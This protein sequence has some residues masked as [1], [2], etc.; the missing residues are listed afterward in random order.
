MSNSSGD[1]E[2][3]FRKV[4]NKD[5]EMEIQKK[6]LAAFS[7]SM[8]KSRLQ[9]ACDKMLVNGKGSKRKAWMMEGKVEQE[10]KVVSVSR[11]TGGKDRHS[12][13]LTAKGLRDRRV[14]LSVPTALQLY[15]LQDRLGYE[16]PSKAV[17]WLIN[18]A[19]SAIDELP[20]LDPE[21]DSAASV[22]NVAHL[23]S[24]NCSN[25]DH[26]VGSPR[27][28]ATA[29][30]ASALTGFKV[31]NDS[32]NARGTN[33]AKAIYGKPLS[34]TT[35]KE[36]DL[37]RTSSS[38]SDGSIKGS[39]EHT[40]NCS[41]SESTSRI[42]SKLK[43]SELATKKSVS[44]GRYRPTIQQMN[45]MQ[46]FLTTGMLN[47]IFPDTFLPAESK[48][49]RDNNPCGVHTQILSKTNNV[50]QVWDY[51]SRLSYTDMLCTQDSHLLQNLSSSSTAPLQKSF[52]RVPSSPGSHIDR[53]S[54]PQSYEMPDSSISSFD[55]KQT[56]PFGVSIEQQCQGQGQDNLCYAN[57][58]NMNM[59][60]VEQVH[61]QQQQEAQMRVKQYAS[62]TV[63]RFSKDINFLTSSLS[64]REL[65]QAI[66]SS[67]TNMPSLS[68][69]HKN[70]YGEVSANP[71]RD[72]APSQDYEVRVIPGIHYA[73]QHK[74]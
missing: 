66:S 31:C 19:K 62:T 69:T 39:A 51:N 30:T 9:E 15:D 6:D 43:E 11:L 12:K 46:H 40:S 7:E 67:I 64:G 59:K 53:N 74:S 73:G 14:R 18:A 41:M 60:R 71:A 25:V 32:I 49:S 10:W 68:H 1:L 56:R 70:V 2:A 72:F 61:Q 28:S 38:I 33:Y 42:E 35:Q 8:N 4:N 27:E 63:P 57:F 54:C 3:C 5:H 29:I 58:S 52:V 23:N 65:H 48:S 45:S 26:F 24:S 37:A 20:V 17:G 13:V 22:V 16:Q 34:I 21:M 55:P 44:S 50:H 36:S 47:S